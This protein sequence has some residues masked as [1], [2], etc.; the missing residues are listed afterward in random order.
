VLMCCMVTAGFMTQSYGVGF[1]GVSVAAFCNV[2]SW[3]RAE[4]FPISPES[5]SAA[6]QTGWWLAALYLL[7]SI[8]S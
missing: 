7:A 1:A 8:F 5:A 4:L 2:Q 6:A 3:R